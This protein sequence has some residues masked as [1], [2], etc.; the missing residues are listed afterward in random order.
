ML[1]DVALLE[2]DF[3]TKIF[4]RSVALLWHVSIFPF[5]FKTGSNRFLIF[6]EDVLTCGMLDPSFMHPIFSKTGSICY[7]VPQYLN[8]GII[9][10]F[11]L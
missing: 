3:E 9:A 2:C 4:F 6:L 8:L 11:K 10:S 7:I 1:K 5:C